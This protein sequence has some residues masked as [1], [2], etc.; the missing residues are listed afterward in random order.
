MEKQ[1]KIEEKRKTRSWKIY[2]TTRIMCSLSGDGE[3]VKLFSKNLGQLSDDE[4]TYKMKVAH[5]MA[6]D[7][8]RDVARDDADMFTY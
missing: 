4:L 3:A 6:D 5:D 1:R 2:Y 7:L 8:L